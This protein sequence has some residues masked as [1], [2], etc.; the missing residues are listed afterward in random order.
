MLELVRDHPATAQVYVM[1]AMRGTT[2]GSEMARRL[3]AACPELW[4]QLT[5]TYTPKNTRDAVDA[6]ALNHS[7]D[8]HNAIG[9][10]DGVLASFVMA[11]MRVGS[12]EMI[13]RLRKWFPWHWEFVRE[14]VVR[15]GI[16]GRIWVEDEK[17]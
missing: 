1:A 13:S 3:Q 2:E 14:S 15:D 12:P 11:A 9:P 6:D 16:D 4:E 5:R 10:Y 17:Q 8:L 7:R